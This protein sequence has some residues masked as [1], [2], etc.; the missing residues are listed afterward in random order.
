AAA[1]PDDHAVQS[2]VLRALSIGC[3][4]S[5]AVDEA[6]AWAKRSLDAARRQPEQRLV[7]DALLS[8]GIACSR[9]GQYD[10]GLEHFRQVLAL[11]ESRGDRSGCMSVLNN[12]G[13][14]CKNLGR[15]DEAVAYLA[16]G[17]AI[18]GDVGDTAA[19]AVLRSNLGEPLLALGRLD[20]AQQA[21]EAAIAALDVA[22]YREGEI[23]ARVT[24]GQVLLALGRADAAQAELEHALRSAEDTGGRND[25]ARAHRT[26]AELHKAAGRFEVALRH[27]EAFHA[28]ERAQFNADSDR[29][30]SALRVQLEVADARHEAELHRL[31]HVEIAQAHDELKALHAALLAADGEKNALLAQ[32][33]E[34]SRTDALTGLANRRWLDERLADE[35]Q[36][37]RRH[38]KPLAV[39]M[40]D[41]DFFKRINDRFG[42]AVGDEVLRRVAAILRERCRSTDLVARYGGEEFCIAFLEADA[43][44]AV[45]SCEAVRSAVAAH[46]WRRVHPAL[47]VTLSIGVADLAREHR[48]DDHP[49]DAHALLADAD[50]QL[51]RAKRDG[52]NRVQWHAS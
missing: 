49:P 3:E 48:G 29:R 52:K 31:Q 16:R 7:A 34:Q 23:H 22:G 5:G 20:E 45:R 32:L 15:H 40:C 37:A 25:A 14:N 13:I 39:A 35:L 11:F 12:L 21:L 30:I 33:A 41:L 19:G 2:R 10:A 8:V 47:A 17:L 6:L 18:A 9:A 43:A 51:Y 4:V 44:H 1:P 38:T 46:D 42:H 28:A 36:R 24:H 26:L 50:R 27:H